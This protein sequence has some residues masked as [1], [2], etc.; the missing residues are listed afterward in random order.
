MARNSEAWARGGAVLS[1]ALA[2]MCCILPLGLGLLGL[3]TTAVAAF[4][5]PLRP[6]FLMLAA[7]LLGVGFYFAFRA[8]PEGEICNTSSRSLSRFSKPALWL[9]TVAVLGLAF[10][11]SIAGIA[12]RGNSELSTATASEI[13]ELR[14]DGMTCEACTSGVRTALLDVPGVIDAAVSYEQK[15]ARVRLRSERPPDS[16]ALLAAV[17]T[18]G[19]SATMA[20]P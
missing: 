8:P 5:E 16:A 3:S 12:A 17:E 20:A 9:S 11:P 6:W 4:F 19:Y 2:S 10:F 13:V 1:A 15:R 7:L 18:A 14:I